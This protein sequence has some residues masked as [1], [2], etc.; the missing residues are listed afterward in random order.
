[1][2]VKVILAIVQEYN[3]PPALDALRRHGLGAARIAST[4]GFW[5]E[6]NVTLLIRVAER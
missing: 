1:M 5:R 2:K 3:A 6:G 4:G